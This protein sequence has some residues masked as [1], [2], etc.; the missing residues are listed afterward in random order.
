MLIPILSKPV[1]CA[2]ASILAGAIPS[3]LVNIAVGCA[4]VGWVGGQQLRPAP[5]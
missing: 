5:P 3:T 1:I 4:G 2:S